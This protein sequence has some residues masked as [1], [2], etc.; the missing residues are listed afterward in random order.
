[1]KLTQ[2]RPYTDHIM[3]TMA[4]PAMASS[5]SAENCSQYPPGPMRFECVSRNNPQTGAKLERCNQ[6]GVQMG[7]QPRGGGGGNGGGLKQ[8]VQSCMQGR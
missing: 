5:A 2:D 1:M 8:Y 6:D 4:L 7:L 3:T